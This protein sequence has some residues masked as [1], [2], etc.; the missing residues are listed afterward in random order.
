MAHQTAEQA[1]EQFA[2]L[3]LGSNSFRLLLVQRQG[4]AVQILERAKEK[5]QLL[6][7]FR[8]GELSQS[9][10]DRGLACLGRYAQR[11]TSLPRAHVM[12]I[13]TH[14]LR[15]GA[16]RGR[17]VAAAEAVM[18]VPLR[19]VSGEEEA[20]LVYRGVLTHAPLHPA[21]RRLVID[22]G[23][24]STEFAWGGAGQPDGV[25]SCKQG[26]VAL[27][28]RFFRHAASVADGFRAAQAYLQDS[29]PALERV[30]E[31]VELVGTSGTIESVQAV[32]AAN[33]WSDR[34]ITA[35]G[36]RRLVEAVQ[37]SRWDAEAG[38][39]G[40]APDR[41]DIFPAGV[42][43]LDVLFRRLDAG[44]MRHVGAAL[45]DGAISA[46]LETADQPGDVRQ[47]T[48][49]GLQQ[50]YGLDRAQARR[51][52]TMALA[53]FDQL[54]PAWLGVVDGERGR[55][56]RQLLAWGAELHEIGL[57]VSP[58]GHQRHGAYLLKHGDLRGFSGAEQSLLA[59]LVRGHRR[60]FPVL[61]FGALERI[62]GRQLIRLVALLRIAVILERSHAD[63]D[64]PQV[65]IRAEQVGVSAEQVGVSAETGPGQHRLTLTIPA[66]WLERHPL[67]RRELAVEP[68]QLALAG[69]ELC[70][71]D[72]QG[73]GRL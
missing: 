73:L 42:A 48:V 53:L 52:R 65:G 33:G 60:G 3:D 46:L 59:L 61:A 5:V 63:G 7:D 17:L 56:W 28:D 51:V 14:A 39:L 57:A 29:L 66:A 24:G 45:E 38:L 64:C 4:A 32:L 13:G 11:L 54:G 49:G 40:L 30:P 72:A 25:L 31:R 50:R 62:E 2:V 19:I 36:L 1:A 70:V 35:T 71:V 12:I 34:S 47:H 58:R 26:C 20:A 9:A 55:D 69:I 23:G 27:A 43:L 10:I 68:A 21:A 6:R 37:D 8:D 18:G 41:V 15:E 44:V 22:I 67:S 16:N